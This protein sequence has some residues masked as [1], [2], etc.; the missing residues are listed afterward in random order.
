M[1]MMIFM[2][3]ERIKELAEEADFVVLEDNESGSLIEW[4][5]NYDKELLKFVELIEQECWAEH[6]AEWKDGWS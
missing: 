2:K 4:E 3:I 1:G 5:H 6:C